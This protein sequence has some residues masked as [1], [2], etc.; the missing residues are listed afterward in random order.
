MHQNCTTVL[1]MGGAVGLKTYLTTVESRVAKTEQMSD[2]CPDPTIATRKLVSD[3]SLLAHAP[4]GEITA[5]ETSF[6]ID[7]VGSLRQA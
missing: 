3:H 7:S 1:C 6:H 2:P 5:C 4:K